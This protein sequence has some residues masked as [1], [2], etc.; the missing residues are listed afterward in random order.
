MLHAA[1]RDKS[2]KG[3]AIDFMDEIF[4]RS[5]LR[6]SLKLLHVEE[7][8]RSNLMKIKCA[9]EVFAEMGI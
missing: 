1:T 5:C 9:K 6:H 3:N 7:K 4:I 8:M 2:A